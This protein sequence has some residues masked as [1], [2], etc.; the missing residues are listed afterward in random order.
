MAVRLLSDYLPEGREFALLLSDRESRG[1]LEED[2]F[3]L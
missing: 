2:F 1:V 3:G